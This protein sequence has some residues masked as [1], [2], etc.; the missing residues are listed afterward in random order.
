MART[1]TP[2]GTDVARPVRCPRCRGPFTQ[3]TRGRPR[4]YCSGACR[5]APH[6]RRADGPKIRGLVSLRQG[7]VRT[8]LAGPPNESVD[9]VLTDPPYEFDRGTTYFPRRCAELSSRDDPGALSRE[10]V[11]CSQTHQVVPPGDQGCLLLHPDSQRGGASDG[12][13]PSRGCH[14]TQLAPPGVRHRWAN[15]IDHM[16]TDPVALRSWRC[17]HRGTADR[18]LP[19]PGEC[20]PPPPCG[21]GPG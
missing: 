15:S 10:T 11:E 14:H 4:R 17:R 3:P 12:A 16:V 9:L 18:R 13:H 2:P 7:D 1:P 8:F 21:R 20:G 5:S 19:L 6:R